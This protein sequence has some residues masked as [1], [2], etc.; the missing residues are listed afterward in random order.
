[1]KHNNNNNDNDKK[2]KKVEVIPKNFYGFTERAN[3]ALQKTKDKQI[4]HEL[5]KFL[6]KQMKNF[7]TYQTDLLI[8]QW[9][10]EY[11]FS[12]K[13]LTQYRAGKDYVELTKA[14]ELREYIFLNYEIKQNS[15]TKEVFIKEKSTNKRITPSELEFNAY[16]A[17]YSTGFIKDLLNSKNKNI[18]VTMEYNPL[19][20]LFEQYANDYKGNDVIGEL[21][22]CITAYDF[23]DKSE[24]GFYQKRLERYLKK[25]L[26]KTV[27]QILGIG[28]NDAMLLWIEPLGGSGKSYINRWL[29]SLQDFYGYYMRISE[30][31]T[32]MPMHLYSSSKLAVDFD[33]LPLTK[34]RYQMFKSYIAAE[35]GQ[36]Y[37]KETKQQQQY[38]RHVSF[39]GSTNKANRAGQKGYLNDADDAIK[40]RIICIEIQGQI[41]YK[42][43]LENIDLKQ[44]WGQ[45]ASLI[46]QAQ[47]SENK[48]LLT[49]ECDYGDLR[50][51]NARYVNANE[52]VSKT[53]LI[54]HIRPATKETGRFLSSEEIIAELHAKGI[55]IDLSPTQIG[56]FLKNNNFIKGRKKQKGWYVL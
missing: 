24:P 9:C 52:Q 47:K 16:N 56:I 15:I 26:A 32:H 5:V 42:Y 2:K 14:E 34:A 17:G 4:Q 39:I 21:A 12:E 6:C 1:M 49:Y 11:R 44:L 33:E 3:I 18:T 36:F 37:D 41:N 35:D 48:D 45:A 43:Y 13:I 31:L 53:V 8:K 54:S 22:R 55:K 25:W 29:F 28:K 19:K 50:E 23:K 30:N 10:E 46:L 20:Q 51:Q 38:E 27:G 7:E 40:R